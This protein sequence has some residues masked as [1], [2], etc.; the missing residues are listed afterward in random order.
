MQRESKFPGL[1]PRPDAAQR[2]LPWPACMSA[3]LLGLLL[4]MADTAWCAGAEEPALSLYYYERPPFHYTDDQGQ[5]AGS[6]AATTESLFRRAGLSLRW[7]RMPANRILNTLRGEQAAAC[8]PGWYA[9]PERRLDFRFSLPMLRDKPLIALV[10][11]DYPVPANTTA[12]SFFESPRLRLLA[13]QNFSQGAY[14]D[15]LIARMPPARVQRVAMEVPDM[16]RMLR[17]D[18]ADA[19]ITTEVEAALFVHAAGLSMGDFQIARFPDVPEVEYRY[20]L[21]SQAVSS[22]TMARIDKAIGPAKP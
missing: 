15:A 22:A 4:P 19:V 8:S 7:V 10:R 2:G 11:E 17:A 1:T 21:C 20:L 5:V 6:I 3:M 18:R 13:K 9:T 12:K 14:M 16:I